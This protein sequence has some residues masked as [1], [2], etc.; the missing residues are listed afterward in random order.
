M[1]SA[2]YPTLPAPD[3]FAPKDVDIRDCIVF[4]PNVTEHS[5]VI[6]DDVA[7]TA[8]AIAELRNSD[9][10]ADLSALCI[11][12]WNLLNE[13][14]EIKV[15]VR[16]EAN[17]QD[18]LSD[19][20]AAGFRPTA[21][22]Q[23]TGGASGWVSYA[24]LDALAEVTGVKEIS[25]ATPPIANDDPVVS[26][27]DRILKAEDLRNLLGVDGSGITVGVISNGVYG[28]QSV[29]ADGELP[30]SF[31]TSYIDP[32][33]S[34]YLNKA[35]G[36]AML[37]IV[38]D[39]APG[40]TLFFSGP[41]DSEEMLDSID[42]LVAQGCDIIVDDLSFLDQPFFDD[43]DVANAALDAIANDDVLYVSAAGNFADRHY[44]ADFTGGQ[45]GTHQFA[46]GEDKLPFLLGPYAVFGGYL[47]WSDEWG[48]SG[49]DY[50]LHLYSGYL[51]GNEI[52]W[53]ENPIY[54]ATGVQDGDD[55]PVET[56][57]LY[58]DSGYY[59]ILGWQ[60]EEV[61]GSGQE[62]ELYTVSYQGIAEQLDYYVAEDSIFGQAASDGVIA[63]GAISAIDP[64]DPNHESIE[65]FS[66]QGPSTVYTFPPGQNPVRTE[67][68]SLDVAGIDG[69]S[70][71]A[72][73]D[74]FFDYE[75]FYGTSAA[76]PHI[77]AI[78][79]L[80]KEIK[81]DLTPAQIVDL[82]GG[83]AYDLGDTGYDGVFGHGRADA[84]A[85]ISAAVGT[86]NLA[87][88]SDTGVSTSDNITMLNNSSTNSRLT[89][90]VG[91]T[92]AGSTVELYYGET[93]IGTAEGEDETTTVTTNGSAT[94]PD[95]WDDIVAKQTVTGKLPS[96]GTAL[97]IKVDTIAPT[98][99]AFARY[100]QGGD[101]HLH[102]T[103]LDTIVITFSEE[104]Y[105]SSANPGDTLSLYNLST[106]QGYT[107]PSAPSLGGQQTNT[108]TWD[109]NELN[110]VSNAGWYRV[111][112]SGSL[113]KDV[114]GNEMGSNYVYGASSP[115][116]AM[117]LPILGDA[118]CNGSVNWS[119]LCTVMSNMGSPG[120][121]QDGDF[122]YDGYVDAADYV[123]V[124]SYY[125]QSLS[126]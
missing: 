45:E 82:I 73:I 11:P 74:G 50:N 101:W 5:P 55:D 34:G 54:S 104:V 93:L 26:D 110:L 67:R 42:W 61:S 66:S 23:S 117:L 125:G 57:E 12:G 112:I 124:K 99:Q 40:A 13:D 64:Y 116:N 83:N 28:W 58:N 100:Y 102:P 32:Y 80:L 123:I 95:G 120:N 91:G 107:P 105:D 96:Y 53:S 1:L 29:K 31:G 115:Q 52:V 10:A 37:E 88:G 16:F 27:G 20:T 90:A 56:I 63:V 62:V 85:I 46:E 98:V 126:R 87:D 22:H 118:D 103:R 72:G 111:T 44:Q 69:V 78:A 21:F 81:P 60:I 41:T 25:F 38:H 6:R 51:D 106:S 9:P 3:L 89:F 68:D 97:S 65:P 121:W 71:K 70:T 114:A 18:I 36:T 4:A 15:I 76:A 108:L 92:V 59:F 122:N 79:A 49:H 35:E 94:L 30:A 33:R 14:G 19:F 77:A 113:L 43:G 17:Q 7:G 84:L 86:P 75:P 39:L 8:A 109:F 119:D 48:Q 47:Q 24:D 2:A